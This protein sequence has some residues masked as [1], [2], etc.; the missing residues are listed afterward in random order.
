MQFYEE[1]GKPYEAAKWRKEL[2]DAEQTLRSVST[3]DKDAKKKPP[4]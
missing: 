3:K 1:T 4:N 2:A